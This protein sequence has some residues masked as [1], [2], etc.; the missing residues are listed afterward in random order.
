MVIQFEWLSPPHKNEQNVPNI[1]TTA[2]TNDHS[3][4]TPT[5]SEKTTKNTKL[6]SLIKQEFQIQ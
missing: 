5:K 1:A 6:M 3:N 2:I 4:C